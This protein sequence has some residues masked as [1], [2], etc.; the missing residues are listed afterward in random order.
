MLDLSALKA[1]ADEKLNVLNKLGLY[2]PTTF[3][4]FFS[5]IWKLKYNDLANQKLRFIQ[6]LLKIVKSRESDKR[7]F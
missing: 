4:V 1:F 5:K 3:F 7:M 2:S 6:M